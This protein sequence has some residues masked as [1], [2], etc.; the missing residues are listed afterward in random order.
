MYWWVF[1][2]ADEIADY[3]GVKIALYFAWLGHYTRALTIP[4]VVGFVFWMVS[5]VLIRYT[6]GT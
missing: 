4:A 5:Q 2:I 6:V 3:F 1:S